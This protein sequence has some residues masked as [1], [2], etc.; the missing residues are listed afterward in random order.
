M[1]QLPPTAKDFF[2]RFL[3]T[4]NRTELRRIDWE[5]FYIFVVVCHKTET[6][7][8]HEDLHRALLDARFRDEVATSL[9]N[10][11]ALGRDILRTPEHPRVRSA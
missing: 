3:S 8:S 7:C 2:S 6:Q 1:D 10:A 5:R 11:Y 9:V 4:A